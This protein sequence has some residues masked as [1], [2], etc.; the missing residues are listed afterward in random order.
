MENNASYKIFLSVVIELFVNAKKQYKGSN[1][2][3]NSLFYFFTDI[4]VYGALILIFA[5]TVFSRGER[6]RITSLPI[7]CKNTVPL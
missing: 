7:Q 1:S 5:K 6:P 4:D 3:I 2:W